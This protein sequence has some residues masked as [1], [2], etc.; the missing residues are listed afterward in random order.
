MGLG[1]AMI[2][3]KY[4]HAFIDKRRGH[5]KPRFYFRRRGHKQIPLPGHPGSEQFNRAYEMAL[6]G[7][8]PAIPI[9]VKRIRAG[10]LGALVIAWF[11]STDFPGS[12]R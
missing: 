6:S 4:V 9:G 3:F 11:N 1:A 2:R 5:A 12:L 7:S 10:S 8:Q